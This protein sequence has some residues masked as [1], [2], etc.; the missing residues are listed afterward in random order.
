MISSTDHVYKTLN[1]D[2]KLVGN[3]YG[4][5]DLDMDNGDYINVI[6]LDSL[7]NACI[8]AILTRFRELKNNPTYSE[9]GCRAHELIKDN[10]RKLTRYKIETY[11][12]DVL[13]K[14]RRIR[15]IN[16]ITVT[17]RDPDYYVEFSVTSI[18]DET[19]KGSLSL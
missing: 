8:I 4:K 3:E 1:E 9:F 5:Y 15:T 19:I 10:Q 6:G 12:N 7:K 18:N 11:I 13:T 16:Y 2:V 14:M 17:Q